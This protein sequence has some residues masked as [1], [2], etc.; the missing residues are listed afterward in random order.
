[1]FMRHW[2]T[3]GWSLGLHTNV[4]A[5]YDSKSSDRGDDKFISINWLMAMASQGR[6]SDRRLAGRRDV[7]LDSDGVADGL[8][9]ARRPP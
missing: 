5:G 7:E 4:F 1:M 3:G 8:A 6:R 2:M 9:V